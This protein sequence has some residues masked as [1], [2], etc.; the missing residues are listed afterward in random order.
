VVVNNHAPSRLLTLVVLA[1]VTL[2]N[3]F[4]AL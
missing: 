4:K 2:G 1:K 3:W